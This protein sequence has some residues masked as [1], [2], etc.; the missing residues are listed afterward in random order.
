MCW[1]SFSCDQAVNL[2]WELSQAK[3]NS[4]WKKNVLLR[5]KQRSYGLIVSAY[6]W[7]SGEKEHAIMRGGVCNV[8]DTRHGE[9]N[10]EE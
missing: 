6:Y 2:I 10:T 8:G 7:G 4:T 1:Y 9:F 3:N 5:K